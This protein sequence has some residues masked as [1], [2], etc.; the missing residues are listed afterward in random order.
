MSRSCTAMSLKMPPPPLTY[1]MGG[2]AGSREQSLTVI[3]SP[4]SPE[5]MPCEEREAREFR[6]RKA[7][8]REAMAFFWG[9]M[10]RREAR[11]LDAEEVGVEAALQG[12][13]E[14]D[15]LLA[16]VVDGLDGL[17]EVRRQRLLAEDVLARVGA[18]LSK[19]RV[20]ARV[21]TWFPAGVQCK[22]RTC[23]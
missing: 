3:T 1:S 4:I 12:G 13:H 11:L 9:G 7:W 10:R 18:R 17:D 20:R 14:L 8:V 19:A 2:G 16:G 23:E 15:A 6:N 21:R 5:S 22:A